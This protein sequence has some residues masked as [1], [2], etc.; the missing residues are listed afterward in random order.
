MI[1]LQVH[2]LGK[3][4]F[5]DSNQTPVA[6][7]LK[8]QELLVYL[9]IHA[10]QPHEREKLSVQLWPNI[11]ENRAKKYLRQALWQLQNSLNDAILPEDSIVQLE[12]SWV[13]FNLTNS[14][15]IDV[16]QYYQTFLQVRDVTAQ[17]MSVK[18]IATVSAA[19]D[20]YRGEFVTGWYHDW[21][22]LERERFQS[23][24][25]AM[26]DKLIDCCLINQ[27]FERG[28]EYAMQMLRYDKA[29]ER[30]HRRLM[31][32]YYLAGNR[33]A[34]LRQYE[35]CAAALAQELNVKPSQRTVALY[36]HIQMDGGHDLKRLFSPT[37][38]TLPTKPEAQPPLF[39]MLQSIHAN[40]LTLQEDM[41]NIKQTLRN[42]D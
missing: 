16:N 18:Q 3:I 7:P 26:L 28:T 27:Q 23:M 33:T 20:L 11:P 19:V 13:Q 41:Q 21:C 37:I 4:Q 12:G 14:I 42:G 39:T 17:A 31:R 2:L 5:F 25:L 1:S 24:L 35:Q 10:N 9:I 30:S 36:Q 40:L 6:L 32:L 34:A 22:L 29:R 38:L 15:W 8:A